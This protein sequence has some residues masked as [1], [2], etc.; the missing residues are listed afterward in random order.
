MLRYRRRLEHIDDTLAAFAK[1]GLADHRIAL[2]LVAFA[3]D[4]KELGRRI[5]V[6]SRK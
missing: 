4:Q 5:D 2:A 3:D 1:D 6:Y